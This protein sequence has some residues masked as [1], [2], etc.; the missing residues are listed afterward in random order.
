MWA[1]VFPKSKVVF[2]ALWEHIEISKIIWGNGRKWKPTY[3]KIFLSWNTGTLPNPYQCHPDR[4]AYPVC[5]A[6]MDAIPKE[7]SLSDILLMSRILPA[8]NLLST[9]AEVH[10]KSC[11]LP[12]NQKFLIMEGYFVDFLSSAGVTAGIT[13][14]GHSL[15]IFPNT[16][17]C[18]ALGS[19][20]R[21]LKISLCFPGVRKAAL[22][23]G[24]AMV[25]PSTVT[26]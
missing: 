20:F 23:V 17:V 22:C 16:T 10:G 14:F 15:Q 24:R 21:K 1:L 7:V 4:C 25:L 19:V 3:E 9:P 13:Y 2:V 11:D 5:T 18:T 26:T 6:S 8:I 12:V